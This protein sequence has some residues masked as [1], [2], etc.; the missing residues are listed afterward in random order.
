MKTIGKCAALLVGGGMLLDAIM[1]VS[2]TVAVF[3]V[4]IAGVI[5]MVA[6]IWPLRRIGLGQRTVSACLLAGCFAGLIALAP[7]VEA[8]NAQELARLEKSD[9]AA[10]LARLKRRDESLWAQELKRIDPEGYRAEMAAR[11]AA[12]RKEKAERRRRLCHSESASYDAYAYAQQEIEDRLKS[13][14]TADFPHI[15]QIRVTRTGACGFIVDGYVD[16]E[17][18]F[19][20]RLRTHFIAE[21]ERD[22]PRERFWFLNRL[23]IDG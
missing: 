11:E 2:L 13:P 7:A 3:G 15:S 9:P 14:S 19:R 16:A 5:G 10:Y 22:F 20:A 17:N 21:V 1:T 23:D 6:L 12:A 4:L 8:E 18:A